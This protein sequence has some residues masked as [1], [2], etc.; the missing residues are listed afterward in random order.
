MPT[1]LESRGDQRRWLDV[2]GLT[3]LKREPDISSIIGEFFRFEEFIR[4]D[5]P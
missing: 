2:L 1:K 3:S 5:H 4:D